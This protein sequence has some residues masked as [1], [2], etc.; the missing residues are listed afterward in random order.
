MK[1]F[2]L[3][4]VAV[5]MM[6]SQAPCDT[7][8]V[9]ETFDSYVDGGGNPDQA[10]FQANWRPDNGDGVEPPLGPA[11]PTE[12]GLLVPDLLEVTAPPNDNPPGLQGIA[13]NAL[14]GNNESTATFSLMPSATEW[15]R[16]GADIFNDGPGTN[17]SASGMRQSVGLRND[18][19]DRDAMTFGCQCG[20]NFLELGFYN[21]AAV[22]PR[23]GLTR[24]NTQF[25]YRIALGSTVPPESL[26]LPNWL[27]FPL[28]PALDVPEGDP[29]QGDYN[30]DFTVDAADYVV[31]RKAGATDTLPNDPTAGTVD[32]SDYDLW[33]TNFGMA[34][35]GDGVVDINDIGEGWH[36]F[37]A[38]I[39]PESITVE[40]DLYRDGINNATGEPG[41]DSSETWPV[42]MNI[43]AA[44]MGAFNSLRIGPP[45]GVSGNDEAVFDNVF[46]TLVDATAAGADLSVSNVPE[47][48]SLIIAVFGLA[49]MVSI[50]RRRRCS[51]D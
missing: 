27:S 38:L 51:N 39:K 49:G 16:F 50:L 31:W 48:A 8:I 25:Q 46:L 4:F 47:P 22:D 36:T 30:D 20:V 6:A 17:D 15:I 37:S 34:T 32:Q 43:A 28:D 26:S 44:E 21:T 23:T 35:A 11:D 18:N 14:N 10:A 9:N 24:G 3:A 41:V 33:R 42:R 5:A 29:P 13:V 12:A 19:Y 7:V 45:S 40:L 2:C 1:R